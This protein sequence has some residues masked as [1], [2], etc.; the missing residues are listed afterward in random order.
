MRLGAPQKDNARE[1]GRCVCQH[2]E[3]RHSQQVRPT[4]QL[5]RGINFNNS[6]AGGSDAQ[7]LPPHEPLHPRKR[8][9]EGLHSEPTYAHDGQSE[10]V[11]RS[12]D[13][14]RPEPCRPITVLRHTDQNSIIFLPPF[15]VKV[16]T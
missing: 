7:E 10:E 16:I 3:R 11:C 12:S 6:G 1:D 9:R 5:Q 13:V 4:A 14:S 8:V 15:D 2:A